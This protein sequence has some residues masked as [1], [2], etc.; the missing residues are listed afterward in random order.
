MCVREAP[1]FAGTQ[2][3]GQSPE[4]CESGGNLLLNWFRPRGYRHFDV[5]V[6]AK[7]ATRAQDPKFVSK[8]S[9]SPLLHY[10]KKEKR[11]KKCSHTGRRF[12]TEKKR[13]IKYASHRDACIYSWYAK[14]LNDA[15]DDHYA[16]A[17]LDESVIAYRALGCSNYDF[18]AAAFR[19]AEANAPVVIL[20]FD[21][22]N[23]FDTLDHALLKR[24]LK[25]VLGVEDLAVD[26]LKV[27]RNITRFHFVDLAELKAHPTLG[28]RLKQRSNGPIATLAEL[29]SGGIT[30][31][32]NPEVAAGRRRGI[33]QGTPISAAASNLYMVDFDAAA[34]NYC[35]AI[36]ALYRR[37]SDDILVICN[38]DHA[39]AANQKICQLIK[40]ERL[41]IESNK[42]EKTDFQKGST[43]QRTGRAAQYLGFT[44]AES[45][46][47]I[48]E[49][50]LARQWRRMK[51]AFCRTKRVAEVRMAAGRS[52]KVYTKRLRR[53]F[54]NIR[55]FDGTVVR[56]LRNFS[57]YGRR[58]AEAFGETEKITHQ[59]KRLERAA[60]RELAALKALRQQK[61]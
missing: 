31:R 10:V 32:A 37:Y 56:S 9:F 27:I 57:S 53:C 29:K 23:F 17:G 24:R 1:G 38:P 39:A 54:T 43:L 35:D 40:D 8:H 18:S 44:L 58:S 28:P 51:R 25:A 33:P 50:S 46:P 22:S 13:P 59:V 49:T 15:L 36:G 34:K 19:F 47:A 12:I 11:Y 26:W 55:V 41:D 42:T 48:R 52:N 21:I 30:F 61:P 7:F 20:A 2:G 5:R 4:L 3:Q 6:D 14:Q 16:N 60:E 45:G